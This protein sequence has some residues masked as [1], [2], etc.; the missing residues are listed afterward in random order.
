MIVRFLNDQFEIEHACI[1]VKMSTLNMNATAL[2]SILQQHLRDVEVADS[3]IVFAT[4]DS[5]S[6]NSSMVDIWNDNARR[7]YGDDYDARFLPWLGCISHGTS[8]SGTAMRKK[9]LHLKEFFRGYKKMSNTSTAARTVWK[10][11]TG[12]ACP[13]LCDNRWWAWYDCAKVVLENWTTVPI[14]LMNLEKRNISEKSTARMMK[15]F[16]D[17]GNW[18]ILEAQIR[19][20]IT[21]GKLFRDCCLLFEGDGFVLPFVSEVLREIRD[22][23]QSVLQFQDQHPLFLDIRKRL[24]ELDIPNERVKTILQKHVFPVVEAGLVHFKDNVWSKLG[25]CFPLFDAASLFHPLVF[26]RKANEPKND[27]GEHPLFQTLDQFCEAVSKLKTISRDVF[28][29]RSLLVGELESFKRVAGQFKAELA[30]DPA[31]HTPSS[32][33]QWWLGLRQRL[34]NFF[35]IACIVVLILP[36]SVVERF[37][38]IIKAHTISQQNAEYEDTFEGRCMAMYNRKK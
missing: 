24:S 37:F 23:M 8:N 16:R 2:L 15:I 32:L 7:L 11:V 22:L 19:G 29:F 5:A 33:W 35:R 9:A 30:S 6:V 13:V 14:F 18:N 17:K 34:P 28:T 1:G 31:K 10:E 27:R 26:L 3:Q 20:V 12:T 38:S 25:T 21:F 36:S 4:T